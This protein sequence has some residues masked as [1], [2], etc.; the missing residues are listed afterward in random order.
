MIKMLGLTSIVVCLAIPA[1]A[2]DQPVSTE[3]L[4]RS[5]LCWK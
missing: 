3:P 5:H 2:D 4:P 1:F